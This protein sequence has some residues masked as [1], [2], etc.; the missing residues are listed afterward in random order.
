MP[1]REALIGSFR[2][3]HIHMERFCVGESMRIGDEQY[4]QDTMSIYPA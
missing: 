2:N 3:E 1:I 4:V